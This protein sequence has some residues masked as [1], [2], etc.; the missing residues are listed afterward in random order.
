MSFKIIELTK[1]NESKYLNQVANLEEVV[2]HRMEQVGQIGQL[3]TTGAED[4]SSYVH[5]DENSVFIS[6]DDNG[7]VNG[8]AYITQGQKPFTYNDITKYFK[9]GEEY[10]KY[11]RSQ[12]PT[13]SDYRKDMLSMYELK[14][15]AFKCAKSSILAEHPEYNG[16]ILAFL[17]HELDEENNHFHEKSP[18]R[19]QLNVRMSDYIKKAAE[20]NPDVMKKYEWFYWTTA[21]DISKEFN[22]PVTLPQDMVELDSVTDMEYSQIL[23]NG[24]LQIYEKPEFDVTKYYAANTSNAVEL[25]TYITAPDT[26]SSGL[27]KALVLQGI[28]KHMNRHFS[29]P[30]QENIFLCSTLHRANLSSKYVS[31]FFG[32]KDSLYVKRRD[33]RNRE[34][35]ICGIS[36]EDY[37]N[38]IRHMQ[39]KLAVLYG[40]NP[41]HLT[42]SPENEISI[43]QEQLSYEKGEINRIKKAK[44]SASSK[45]FTAK[46]ATTPISYEKRK[47][48]KVRSLNRR[49]S[50]L[51]QSL[52]SINNFPELEDR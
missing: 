47:I 9:T 26:R 13:D 46:R 31:E 14:L 8:A 52:G 21:D 3:F 40:Y 43:L 11:V 35:H 30:S 1:D 12:Y 23:K 28:I 25:D 50:S 38:Y 16:D 17:Q 7:N 6:L 5:S 49:I 15:D 48:D 36:R 34:V 18:L 27:A 33:G 45:K 41:E 39:E 2:L 29:D 10:R 37:P 51:Q 42:V 20:S 24:P 22:R 32:L 44:S 19:E 4:I